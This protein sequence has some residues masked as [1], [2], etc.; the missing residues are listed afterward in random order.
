[1]ENTAPVKSGIKH[2]GNLREVYEINLTEHHRAL[3]DA[4]AAGHL[5]NLINQA[6]NEAERNAAAA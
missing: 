1:M 2:L 6:R 5:L 4:R 3:C